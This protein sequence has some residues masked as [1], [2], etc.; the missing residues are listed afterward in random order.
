MNKLFFML[1]LVWGVQTGCGYH[2]LRGDKVLGHVKL[3][4]APIHEP[5]VIGIST[6]LTR[7]IETE[8][9]QQGLTIVDDDSS[10]PLR[11]LIELKNPRTTTTVISSIDRGVPVYRESLTLVASIQDTATGQTQWTTQLSENDLFKQDADTDGDTAL[12]TEAS[13]QRTLDRL[14]RLFALELSGRM[15]VASLPANEAN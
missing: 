3:A 11:L 7:H 1:L 9:L 6:V 4:I 12:L 14:A 13:R 2:V 15:L 8:L 5:T 10:A